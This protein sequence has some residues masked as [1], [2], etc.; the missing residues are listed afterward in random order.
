M[1]FVHHET[2][3][4]AATEGYT[5]RRGSDGGGTTAPLVVVT[6]SRYGKHR[7]YVQTADKQNVGWVDLDTGQRSLDRPE[8]AAE[9]ETALSE[10]PLLDPA[11]FYSPRRTFTHSPDPAAD[12]MANR[13]GEQLEAQMAAAVEAGLEPEPVRPDFQGKRAYSSWQLG[14]LGER[15]VAEEL[16]RLVALELGW[17]YLNSI[18]VGVNNSDIDHL[19]V[20]PGGVFTINAKHHHNGKIWVGEDAFMVNGTWKPYI[21]NSR[22]EADRAARLLATAARTEVPIRGMVVPVGIAQLVV[23]EQPADVVVVGESDLVDFLVD[24]PAILDSYTIAVILTC[25]RLNSTWR[26]VAV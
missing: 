7:L 1:R 18:P 26:A 9:F 5:P 8:L 4:V 2:L 10:A 12:L 23:K 14:V 6:W 13:P 17:A 20:G 19:V 25:A 16:D 3:E 24:Q 21:G 11:G 15:M 22:F